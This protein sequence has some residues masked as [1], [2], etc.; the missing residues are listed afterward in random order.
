[1]ALIGLVLVADARKL[2]G[3]LRDFDLALLLPVLGRSL[4]NYALRFVRW[5][6]YLKALGVRLAHARSLGVFLVGFL[7][8]V[9]PGKAVER[10]GK[11]YC[12]NACAYD[13]TETTC[14]CVHDRC[15][16]HEHEK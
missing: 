5:E 9:T 15:E 2:A 12:S 1:M 14:V 10:A 11:V 3:R 8:S 4:V 7:L 16:D 6:I 13:C